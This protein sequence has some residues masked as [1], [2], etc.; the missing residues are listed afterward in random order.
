[1]AL[2]SLRPQSQSANE[3]ETKELTNIE[4]ADGQQNS[5]AP[6]FIPTSARAIFVDIIFETRDP[7]LRR[8]FS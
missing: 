1:M 4:A 8:E 2:L 6:S 7:A 5:R 3:H